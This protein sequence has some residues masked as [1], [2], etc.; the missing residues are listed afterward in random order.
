MVLQVQ[1]S[2]L[3][4]EGIQDLVVPSW[5]VIRAHRSWVEIADQVKVVTD[6]VAMEVEVEESMETAGTED[7]EHGSC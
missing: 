4:S 3:F 6:R 1:E 2:A 5:E 7:E